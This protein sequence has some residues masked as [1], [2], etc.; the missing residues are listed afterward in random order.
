MLLARILFVALSLLSSAKIYATPCP[1][2]G[3]NMLGDIS[4]QCIFPVR[5]GGIIELGANDSETDDQSMSPICVCN[6]GAVPRVGLSVSFWEPARLIDTVSEPYCMM[7]LGANIGNPT[8]GHLDGSLVRNRVQSKA[9]QQMHYYIFPAWKI[10]DMFTDIPC[11]EDKGFDVAMMTEVVP[12][13]NND[14]LS[15]LVNP[16]AILFANPA[17]ALACAAD[18]ASALFNKPQNALFWCM[19][20]WGLTYPLAG[21]ITAPDYVEANAALAARSIFFMGRIGLLRDTGA[22]GCTFSYTP[23]W[24][25]NRYKLQLAKPVKDSSCHAI[26]KSGLLWTHY[27]QPP[28]GAD[29][30]MWVQFRKLNCCMSYDYAN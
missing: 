21:S 19:G 23:I 12:T 16:E 4:W 9:F 10:L 24:H 7:P 28:V 17:A 25:K 2:D 5:I 18:A 29:N 8:P 26:G 1:T 6:G 15:L 30:F 14:I 27:K 11:M 3:M 13:W 22:D 20:S